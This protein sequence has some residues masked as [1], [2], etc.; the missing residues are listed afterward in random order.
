MI[1][2]KNIYRKQ[3]DWWQPSLTSALLLYYS[4]HS[5]EN[6]DDFYYLIALIHEKSFVAKLWELFSISKDYTLTMHDI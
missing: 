6:D 3:F 5:A 2:G 4:S 1:D